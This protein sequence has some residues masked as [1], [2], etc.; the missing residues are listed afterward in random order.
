VARSLALLAVAFAV[1]G[2]TVAG[3]SPAARSVIGEPLSPP[4]SAGHSIQPGSTSPEASH[5]VTDVQLPASII[6]PIVAAVARDAGVPLEAVV[7][8]LAEAVT[9]PNGGLGCPEPGMVY[10]QVQV[11]GY[12]VVLEA[13]GTTYDYRG[14]AGRP[15]RRCGSVDR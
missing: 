5:T 10:T 9:F 8:R 3:A 4:A 15:A 7:V 6:D 14:T 1:A 11:D 2:C 12:R 13:D